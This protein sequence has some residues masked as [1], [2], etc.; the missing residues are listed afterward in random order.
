MVLQLGNRAVRSATLLAAACLAATQLVLTRAPAAEADP[1]VPPVLSG[2]TWLAHHRDELMPYWLVPEAFGDPVGNF[3][4]YR[5]TDG[6][7]LSELP[8]RGASTLGRGVY[9]YSLAFMLTGDDRYLTYAR[10]GLDWIETKLEDPV[11]GG[12]FAELDASGDPVD[13]SANKNLFDLASVGLGYAMYFNATRDPEVEARLLEI[14]DLVFG[15]YYDSAANRLK[16]ALNYDLSTEVDTGG[17]GGDI[18][19]VGVGSLAEVHTV[20]GNLRA[21]TSR[22]ATACR[23]SRSAAT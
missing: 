20:S 16:D 18:T 4:S 19:L 1:D 17:N 5:G 13:P 12:Y 7:L 21:R 8:N 15:P 2:D 9:G 14:R 10:A 23:S 3:P 6:E 11:H 22:T